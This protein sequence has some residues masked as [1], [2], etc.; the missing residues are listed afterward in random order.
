MNTIRKSLERR[1]LAFKLALAVVGMMLIVLAIGI[2]SLLVQQSLS[3]KVQLIHEQGMVGVVN[4]K[5]LQ[6]YY[7]QIGRTIRQAILAPDAKGRELALK[8]LVHAKAQIPKEIAEL[9]P[10]ILEEAQKQRLARFEEK[11]AEYTRNVD[12]AV[13]LAAKGPAYAYEARALVGALNFQAAGQAANDILEEL[14]HTKE[15]S[16]ALRVQEAQREAAAGVWLAMAIVGGGLLAGLL[17][18]FGV[19]QSI[20]LPLYRIRDAV[21]QLSSDKFDRQLPHT[22]YPNEIGDLSRA[23]A[24]LQQEARQMETERWVK[25]HIADIAAKLQQA[26]TFTDLTQLFFSSV[27]PLINLGHGV[28]YIHEAEQRRLRLISSYAFRERKNIDQYFALG[29]GLV[30]QCALERVPMIITE[31][32]AD[33]VHIGSSLG[34]GVPRALVLRPVLRNDR[35]LGVLE[36]ASFDY[37][38]LRQEALLE[39]L[40]PILAMNM[41]ILERSVKAEQLLK[42]TQRQAESM[43]KQAAHLEEQT[44]E[45]EAQQ[46]SLKETSANLALLEE[47]SRL[48][49]DSVK[50]GIVG[51]DA[52]GLIS[53]ANPAGH[54]MLGFTADEFVG[55]NMHSLVHHHYADGGDFPKLECR[56]YL[57]AQDG[58]QR[59]VDDEVL[60]CKDGS[61][62]PVEYSTTPVYKDGAI[63]GSVIVY[64]D[65]TE[66]KQALEK[67]E[68]GGSMMAA[69]IDSIP[70]LIFYKDVDGRYTGCNNAFAELI[71][72]NAQDIVGKNAFDLFPPDKAEIFHNKDQELLASMASTSQVE[73]VAYPDGRRM[74]LD[75]VKA[76][77]LDGKGQLLG[78]LGIGRD[79]TKQKEAEDKLRAAMQLAEEATKAK[80]DFLANMSHEIRTPMNAIIGMS[81]LAL[82]TDL[83]KKQRNYIEKVHRS[84]ENLLGIINDILDF[85]K[86][87][88]GK[89]SMET[90]DFHLEDV[91][92]NLANLV[93][94]KAEDKGLELLFN[95]AAGVPTALKGDPLRLG[96]IL[97]NLGNN[98]VKFTEQGEIVVGIEKVSEDANGVE[99]H[100]WV[101]DSGIGMTPEQCAKMFQSFSQADASTTRKYGGT[102]LGLAISKNLVEAMGGRIWVESEAG[103]GSNFH[104]HARFGLQ[105][106]QLETRASAK[107]ESQTEAMAQLAGAR[108]LLVEDNEMNQELA[109]ELLRNAGVQVVLANHG[110]EAVDILANDP[111]F[112]GVLMDCQMPVMDG[113]SATREIRR[114]PQFKDL[115][116][117]AMTANAMAGD[118]EKVIEAG[119]WD[120]IAKPL[121]VGEMFATIARWIKPRGTKGALPLAVQEA[122]APAQTPQPDLPG[123]DVKA[124]MATTMDNEKLYTRLLVKFRDSQGNFADLFAA[125]RASPDATAAARAAHTL[126][127]TAGNIGAKGVQAAAA[128]LEHAFMINAATEHIDAL[129]AKTLAQ[130]EPVVRGLQGVS[131][132][133]VKELKAPVARSNGTAQLQRALERL[134]GLLKD[135][136]SDAVEALD[137]LVAL[138][139]G[140]PLAARLARVGDAMA[141]FDF[142]AALTALKQDAA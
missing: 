44:V 116:I 45:L 37:S 29:Q 108:V 121:N 115:P 141:D 38:D 22:D 9:R 2:Q 24:V 83:D 16:A 133:S 130:L 40:M 134:T 81:H 25:T 135:C 139:Q 12:L 114:K 23:I 100:F 5:N 39:G 107:A 13:T 96:Q 98:A 99:L 97:I 142:D 47:R 80:S 76:P 48:I 54:A 110:Q 53:F 36:L 71:G 123:I 125:A 104:F 126:K 19:S 68:R 64:R 103:K 31:P 4:V 127:G 94:M 77:I 92:D 136:D 1:S 105:E 62:V 52:H 67:I 46:K 101:K 113:Y 28:F 50:D 32:P 122:S 6:I 111:N 3:D 51:L 43:E 17:F 75:V 137:E 88:A 57:S 8:Q 35:L 73:W 58:Q 87:E 30:G 106:N 11:F 15:A 61:A 63:V 82:Q 21:Q 60:W 112:D 69:L 74:L 91:M 93:G 65:I 86:I 41:E 33:Y 20:R 14:A 10:S 118:K 79:T 138:A 26:R 119:M 120:H 89:M 72:R 27:G 84:G 78:L 18:G 55:Q 102:G 59:T 128:E 66:R 42:E 129:L 117:I 85:S 34:E 124:G 49:L 131:T 70:D 56:M 7:T 90:I 109:Q 132:T 140:T 95:T